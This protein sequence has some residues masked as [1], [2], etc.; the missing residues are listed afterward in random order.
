M[1]TKGLQHRCA[2]M[3]VPRSGFQGVSTLLVPKVKWPCISSFLSVPWGVTATRRW[4]HMDVGCVAASCD[5]VTG[6]K[7]ERGRVLPTTGLD[8]EKEMAAHSSILAWK[9]PWTEEHGRL[10]SMGLQRVRHDWAT[11][12]VSLSGLGLRQIVGKQVNGDL[13]NKELLSERPK[14]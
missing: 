6:Q 9:I 4:V 1:R 5:P 8:L 10:Q 13:N 7:G 12:S 3:A 2:H 11:S 14:A